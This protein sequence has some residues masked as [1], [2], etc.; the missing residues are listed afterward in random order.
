M[1]HPS[2]SILYADPPWQFKSRGAARRV[3]SRDNRPTGRI[4][5]YQTM[6]LA[7]ICAVPVTDICA[8]DCLLFLRATYPLLPQAFEVISAWGFQFKTV[9]LT[10]FKRT[11]SGSGFHFGM[12]YWSRANPGL[13][14]LAARGH[15]RGGSAQDWLQGWPRRQ[16]GLPCAISQ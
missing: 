1:N 15:P 13:C 10:W 2:F 16:K 9:G 12:G 11:A 7:A 5:P 14:L 6:D 3:P 4:L 8:P